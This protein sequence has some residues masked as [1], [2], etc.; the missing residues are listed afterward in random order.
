[1]SSIQH[2]LESPYTGLSVA[3]ILGALALSGKFTVTATQTL[4][5]AA[6]AVALVGLRS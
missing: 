6:W 3:I 2:F 1:M 4:L 5:V